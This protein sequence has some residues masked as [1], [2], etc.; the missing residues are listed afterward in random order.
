MK[1]QQ[2]SFVATDSNGE[3]VGI[4]PARPLIPSLEPEPTSNG[5]THKDELDSTVHNHGFAPGPY[6]RGSYLGQGGWSRVYKV[7]RLS[8][9]RIFAG[10]ASEAIEQLRREAE[11]LRTLRHEHIV[12]YVDWYEDS[13]TPAATLLMTEICHEGTL[14]M[15]IDNAPMEGLGDKETLQVTLQISKALE[16]LHD[17]KLFHSDIKPR[18]I[19]VQSFEPVFVVLGDCGDIKPTTEPHRSSGTPAYWSPQMVKHRRHWG[20][21]D[22]IWA[23][24]ITVL[25]M[26]GQWPQVVYTKKDLR[27]YP[28]RCFDHTKDLRTLNPTHDVVRLA[29]RMMVWEPET[30]A[31]AAECVRLAGD[32]YAGCR[33]GRKLEILVPEDFE[34]ITFW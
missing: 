3:N 1:P 10:K 15:W 2:W 19:L 32:M 20:A 23:L 31:R 21:P 7:M 28:R 5:W 9:K 12:K 34:A 33:N 4:I 29:S 18:N 22:D 11:I 17:E 8:D 27:K 25:G 14:Q 6:V 24:G 13:E 16:Y 26:I 30:R